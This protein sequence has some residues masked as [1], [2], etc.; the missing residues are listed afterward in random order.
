MIRP[1]VISTFRHEQDP[2]PKQVTLTW[3]DLVERLTTFERRDRKEGAPLWSPTSYRPGTKRAA[4]NV[5]AVTLAV[6]DLD[7]GVVYSEV[8]EHLH[9]L[10]VAFVLHSTF[11]SE[12]NTPRLRVVI[13]LAKP[14]AARDWPSIKKRLDYHVFK[15]SDPNTADASRIY[16]WPIARPG[17][18]TFAEQ[19]DGALLD[20]YALPEAPNEDVRGNGHKPAKDRDLMALGRDLAAATEALNRLSQHRCDDYHE[21][22]SIGMALSDLGDAGLQLWDTWSRKSAKYQAG[23]CAQKW[24]SLEPGNGITLGTLFHKAEEDSPSPQVKTGQGKPLGVAKPSIE[25]TETPNILRLA[26]V[27]PQPVRWLWPGRIPLGKLTILDGDPGLGKSLL[28][29]DLAARVS[30]GRPMPDGAQSELPGPAGVVLLTAE[31]DPADTIRPRLDAA[32]G[33]CQR[34]VLLQSIKE[35]MTLPDGTVKERIRLPNLTDIAALEKAIAEVGA[36]LVIVDPIVAY[37]AGADT[38]ID[39]EV[40]T[41]LARL[42]DVA[43]RTGTAIL[44]VRHLNKMGGSNP[45]YRGGGSIGFIASARSGLLVALDPDDPEEK[46]HILASTKSNLAELPPSLAYVIEAPTGVAQIAWLG[47]SEQTA[48][49]LLA[50]PTDS[51][52]RTA[53]DEAKEFLRDLLADG[54]VEAKRVKAEARDAGI[55]ERTLARAKQLLGAQAEKTGFGDEGKWT[56]RLPEPKQADEQ[57]KD[58]K[59]PLRVPKNIYIE[60]LASLGNFGT[61]RQSGRLLDDEVDRGPLQGEILARAENH[62]WPEL[63][64]APGRKVMAG[65]EAWTKVIE[66]APL[67]DL[68]LIVAALRRLPDG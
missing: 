53:L 46:R 65:Q 67:E 31:D 43:Q 8:V 56:W 35:T 37:T 3:P 7:H 36:K 21:W 33:E 57:P 44:A 63:P 26:D 6:G 54:P 66:W 38:H 5:E 23:V 52:E 47:P 17:A 59:K 64:F 1:L 24:A 51:D 16:Y 49:T 2:W 62:G 20:A 14:V 9:N 42:A 15:H 4:Q 39:S 55:A 30:T 61:L 34:I 10:R 58:A 32:G 40:R 29:L 13:P 68:R 60:S 45:L 27:A 12:P 50:A 18:L 28:T 11:R 25:C 41:V 22:L 19:G 48:R